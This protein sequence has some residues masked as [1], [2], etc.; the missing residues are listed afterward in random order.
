M[1]IERRVKMMTAVRQKSA[2]RC[3]VVRKQYFLSFDGLIVQINKVS[4]SIIR[5]EKREEVKW[6]N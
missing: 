2:R 5:E 3:Q 6:A 4:K 1:P